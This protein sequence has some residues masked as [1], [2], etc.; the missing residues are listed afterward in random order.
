VLL[1]P[2]WVLQQALLELLE[3]LSLKLPVLHLLVLAG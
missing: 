3:F 2:L 1:Q